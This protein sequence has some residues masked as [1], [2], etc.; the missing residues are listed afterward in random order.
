M[1]G[2]PFK[3]EETPLECI[4]K[5]WNFFFNQRLKKS[6]TVAVPDLYVNLGVDKNGLK[7]GI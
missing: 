5:N 4:L 3:P 6:S 1:R 2:S 7:T